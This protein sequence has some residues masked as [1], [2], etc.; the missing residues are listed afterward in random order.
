MKLVNGID[1]VIAEDL[2]PFQL[3]GHKGRI[4]KEIYK[5]DLTEIPGT[6][7]LSNPKEIIFDTMQLISDVFGSY[8]SFISVNGAT[9]AVLGAISTA[10]NEG[11][12]VI[13]LRN[14]HISVYNAIYLLGLKPKYIYM[15]ESILGRLEELITDKTK[16]VIL[17]S[18][19]FFGEII[20]DEVF[21]YLK[22]KDLTIIVDEAHGSHLL[23]IDE[24]L[25]AMRY[26]DIVIHSFHKTLPSMTSTAIMHLCTNR[27]TRTLAQKNILLF[28]TTSPNYVMMRSIDLAMDIYINKG[29]SLM[30]ELIDNIEEFKSNLEN[31]TDFFISYPEGLYDKTRLLIKHKDIV[32]YKIIDEDLRRYGVQTEFY[33]QRGLLLIPSIMNVKSD[34]SAL[35]NALKKVKIV[36][37]EAIEY[38][39]FKPKKKYE[40]RNA[41]LKESVSRSFKEAV[42]SVVTEYIIPYPPGSPIIV[43]GEI[44]SE[45]LSR[46][47][48]KFEGSVIGLDYEG[49]ISVLE[50]EEW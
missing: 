36:K 24:K 5:Y 32:N 9:G 48:E 38:K 2:I 29:L 23:L 17:T 4:E 13:I 7:N 47:L 30:K 21:E 20:E 31:E 40:I 1:K 43:P 25:S 18:P 15:G 50:E 46:Y 41:F 34:F 3:P 37:E 27:F 35:L 49:Y 19:T 10:F 42:G 6:D 45:E 11:D 28:Q 8:H 26:A 39:L 14:S 12:E 44:M 22:K 33:S 16:G